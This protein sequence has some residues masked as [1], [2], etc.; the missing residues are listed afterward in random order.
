[1]LQ[2]RL[3]CNLMPYRD[4]TDVTFS[5]FQK[6]LEEPA[7]Y[8]IDAYMIVYSCADRNSFRAASQVLKRLKEETGSSKT[9]MIVANK[10]DLARKRQV[11]YDGRFLIY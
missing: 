8:D 11:N 9:V 1:M 3:S 4:C 5:L 7:D 6:I 10:V 2:Y